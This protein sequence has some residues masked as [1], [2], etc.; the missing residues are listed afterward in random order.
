MRGFALGKLEEAGDMGV[1]VKLTAMEQ[2]MERAGD[3]EGEEKPADS[4]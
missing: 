3:A 1:S 4:A 2:R